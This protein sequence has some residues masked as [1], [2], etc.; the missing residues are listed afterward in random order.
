MQPITI[1]SERSGPRLKY[2]L[3]WL[4]TG[5]LHIPYTMVDHARDIAQ[6]S[7][8]IAYGTSL[9]GALSIPAHGL[10]WQDGIKQ[11]EVNIGTWK[12]TPVIFSFPGSD[13]SLP[14][15]IFSAIF[16]LLSRYEEY[17][18]YTPDK[19]GRY[20]ATHSF[21]FQHGWLRRPLLD[22]WLLPFRILLQEQCGISA[23]VPAFSFRPTYD[24]DIAWS[25]KHKG[26]ARNAGGLV[27]DVFSGRIGL[28]LERLSVLGGT[29]KDPYDSFHLILELHRGQPVLPL[30]FI[31]AAL[32]STAYD[33]NISPAA[34]QM[35]ALLKQLASSG[36]IG[37][38]PSFYSDTDPATWN[39]E[40]DILT[41]LCGQNI[42][43]SRQ[44]YI[45]MH[46]PA[47]YRFLSANGI[48]DDYSMGYGT[49]LGFR[50]GTGRPFLWYDLETEQTTSL[51]IHPFCF[52]DS[53]AHHEEKL[54]CSEAFHVLDQ[55]T[56]K[57][58]ITGS[59]LITVFHNFSLGTAADWKGWRENYA[60]FITSL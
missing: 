51:A 45:K 44:H 20:P 41:Q 50:A 17:Y 11:Q 23:A 6:G 34:P 10:L 26:F 43:A 47:T 40:K 31:L 55:M 2:V 4:L 48:R 60:Q 35:Q 56:Q 46:L 49:H 19:Y 3:D 13:H 21:L 28:A 8:V 38:H 42:T 39:R 5:Q 30:F 25:Y 27:R 54:E 52:M 18:N 33:K 12:D 9:P 36:E 59:N 58:R 15:D 37:M 57:L 1:Y 29:T 22:E 24:I 16:F 14:F 7:P 53:T 32:Q